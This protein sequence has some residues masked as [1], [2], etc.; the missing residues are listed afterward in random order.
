MWSQYVDAMRATARHEV[1][2]RP[3]SSGGTCSRPYN[4]SRFAATLSCN[5]IS[6]SISGSHCIASPNTSSSAAT[7][8]VAH[9][10][11]QLAQS[12]PPRLMNFFKRFPPPQLAAASTSTSAA[13]AASIEIASNTSSSDPNAPATTSIPIESAFSDITSWKKNPFLPFRNPST[14][15]WHP[16]HYSL[17]RQADLF[18][19]A[20]LHHTLPLMP[21]SPKH[22]EIK[23]QK[24]I[25]H[26]LRVKG[27]GTGQRVKG[28]YWE[29]TLK[30]RLETRR[31]AMEAMPDMINLWKER[32]HGMGWKKYPRGKPGS[33]EVFK[34]DMRHAWVHE[35]A[36]AS[37]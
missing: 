9:Q 19:L 10:H 29:R 26:G 21:P 33:E 7:M 36:P 37:A 24:R 27:T 13:P 15:A 31:K 17:R 4:H 8:A 6:R 23:Q 18:K 16:P 32:G 11:M 3:T 22:P 30:T 14:G 35:R 25:E 20:A 12:L 2:R 28:K 34:P 1:T 5:C